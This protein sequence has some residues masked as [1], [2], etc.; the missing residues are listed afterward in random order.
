MRSC[1]RFLGH[2]AENV[3]RVG[4]K[5]RRCFRKS[6]NSVGVATDASSDDQIRYGLW[7]RAELV[8]LADERHRC[9][10]RSKV[11]FSGHLPAKS[12]QIRLERPRNQNRLPTSF[13]DE[14]NATS[15]GPQLAP[16]NVNAILPQ[17]HWR[18][19]TSPREF[20]RL[21]DEL[22]DLATVR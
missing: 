20:P 6:R 10:V 11:G 14:V 15:A 12:S 22:H 17:L 5:A 19:G 2:L 7:A 8:T 4:Q 16:N 1:G 13:R 3:A 18:R 21:K 9:S